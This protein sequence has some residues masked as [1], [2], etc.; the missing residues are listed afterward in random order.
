MILRVLTEEG[1]WIVEGLYHKLKNL[2]KHPIK[3]YSCLFSENYSN[4]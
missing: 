4:G 2:R 3:I 1:Q